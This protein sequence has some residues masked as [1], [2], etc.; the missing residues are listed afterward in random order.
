MSDQYE[1][2][3]VG[4]EYEVLL[5]GKVLIVATYKDMFVGAYGDSGEYHTVI[6]DANGVEVRAGI[7]TRLKLKP[8]QNPLIDFNW[9]EY[10]KGGYEA[11]DIYR[12][13]ST[14][15]RMVDNP[16]VGSHSSYTID[17]RQSINS[18]SHT[19]KMRKI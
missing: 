5:I 2:I 8:K 1:E 9:E 13:L 16:L 4:E 14:K 15:I 6:F 17:G 11:V 19:L 3:Q 10:K 18:E 12:D 7:K